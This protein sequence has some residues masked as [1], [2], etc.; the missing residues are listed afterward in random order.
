MHIFQELLHK[1]DGAGV[2]EAGLSELG[3]RLPDRPGGPAQRQER[4][5]G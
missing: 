3:Q 5:A 1:D 2:T 4:G